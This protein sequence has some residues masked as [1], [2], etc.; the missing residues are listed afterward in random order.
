MN[1][2]VLGIEK[3]ES[4]TLLS[5]VPNDP[6]LNNQWGLSNTSSYG[7]WAS[8]IGSKD[9]VVAVIDSGIDL[10]HQDLKNNVWINPGEIPN[11][12][13][14]NEGNGYIDDINGWNFFNNT[15]VVQDNYGH[16]TH[17]AGIIGAEGNNSL[18]IAGI[19]WHVSIMPLKF[20]DD[21]GLGSN[22]GAIQ[23]M[24]YLLM[25]K[26]SYH[27]N[28]VAV[29]TSWESMGGFSS[30]LYGEI[31]KLNDAGIILTVAAGNSGVDTDVTL[32]YPSCYDSP[33]VISVGALDVDGVSLAGLSNYGKNT[34]DLAA[35]GTMIYSTLPWNSYGNLTG[36]S[37]A[38]PFVAG[39]VALLNSIKPNLSIAEVKAAI[40]GSV[41]KLPGLFEKVA[42]GGKL[43]IEAAVDNLLGI[44]YYHNKLPF[45][46]ITSQ[47]LRSIGGWVQD[48][49]GNKVIGIQL[50]IDNKLVSSKVCNSD[51]SF[52]FNLGVLNVGDHV[53]NIKAQDSQTRSWGSISSTTVTVPAP[54]VE[55]SSVSLSRVVGWAYSARL[56][57]APVMIRVFVND[58]LV[59]SQY[60]NQYRPVLKATLGYAYHGFNIGLNRYWFHKGDNVVKI[61]T[62]D[63]VSKQVSL[64]G[65]YQLRK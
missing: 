65:T 1:K 51:G 11:D 21:R 29:N 37:M 26:N 35:P 38:S 2:K 58:R 10:T 49:D 7:A 32:K 14:D 46:N 18:G 9:V 5:V 43:N 27:I 41:D 39:T 13:I 44:P 48:P 23:A 6:L 60:A 8:T 56:G 50:W 17:I 57:N 40:F 62:F 53:I 52:V 64:V 30:M 31:Q 33:N 55:V 59:A 63:P 22:G 4:K 20:M 54:V 42:T 36:T 15:N 25:M 19:N 45:G 34:V 16:G 47:T 28:V 61:V 12:G 3:L 24:E